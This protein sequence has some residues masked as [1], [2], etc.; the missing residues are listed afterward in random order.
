MSG[1][2]DN[3]QFEV[4]RDEADLRL[5]R[6]LARHSGI[7]RARLEV[8]AV[9]V[10]GVAARG[11][12]RVDCGCRV[13]AEVRDRA[14]DAPPADATL[15]LDVVH[16]DADVIV[17]DK[18][19]GM[20]VH[21]PRAAPTRGGTLVNA[22][23]A[24]YP[25]IADLTATGPDMAAERPGVV[26]RIDRMTSGL[27]VVA[28]SA[29][30]LSSLGDQAASHA[31]DRV[32]AA[33]CGGHLTTETGIID[34]P[35]GR[36]AGARHLGVEAGG[37]AARSRYAVEA[38]W[39]RPAVSAVTVTLETGR[40]HQIRVHMS[41][42]GHPVLGDTAYGG[43][44]TAGAERQMLHACHLGFTHPG[45]GAWVEFDS[46]L[47]DDMRAV[48]ETLGP[49]SRGSVPNDWLAPSVRPDNH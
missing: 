20:P 46:A 21:A 49:P 38:E 22:L 32:Y 13:E 45:S 47:P 43:R 33:L 44:E 23:L 12:D 48:G 19:A 36:R 9:R 11:K 30:A 29:R 26:H 41:A 37:R 1:P 16:V 24:R 27:L 3:L 10:D 42:I 28:R 15:E 18:A 34:A 5:D 35:I 39:D 7:P 25:E 8:L 17:V 2:S 14:R 40:T 4:T 6:L 31:F